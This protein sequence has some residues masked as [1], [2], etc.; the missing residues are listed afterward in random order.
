MGIIG[1]D[2]KYKLIKNFL[3]EK[4]I[5]LLKEYCIIKH[6]LF[7]Q[8]PDQ[9]K[10]LWTTHFYGDPI[11]ESLLINKKTKLEKEVGKKLN[12]T[13]SFWRMYTCGDDLKQHKDR[14]SCEISVTIHIDG[15]SKWP[16]YMDGKEVVTE[17]GDA[18]AY[19]GMELAHFRKPLE[20]D[21]HTQCFL[22]YVDKDGP[23]SGYKLDNRLTYG[24]EKK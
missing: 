3:I 19:L 6:R 9:N 11:M 8:N 21:Y 14:P 15:A 2:F 1:K 16:I 22:H 18:V 5:K 24:L 4:E 23:H 7:F 17:K 13:Y 12:A 20:A 10:Q